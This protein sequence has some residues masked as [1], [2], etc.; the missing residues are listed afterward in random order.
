MHARGGELHGDPRPWDRL[1]ARCRLAPRRAADPPDGVDQ[2]R[3]RHRVHGVDRLPARRHDGHQRARPRGHRGG[4]RR[5]GRRAAGLP[6]PRPRVPAPREG[7][8]RASARRPHRGGRRPRAARRALP[9]GRDLRGDARGRDDGPAAGA[10]PRRAGLRPE[11]DLDRRPDRVPATARGAR[12][13]GRRGHAAHRMGGLPR[14]RLRQHRRRADP[15]CP[16]ARRPRRRRQGAH[17]CPLRVPHG[18]RV[19]VAAVRLRPPARR[20]ARTGGRGRPGRRPVHARARGSCDRPD[21]QAPRLRAAGPRP[22]HRRGEHRA[23]VRG[24]PAR[25]R[26][27]SADPVR[28]RGALD[29]AA[30]EQPRQAS[31]PRRLRAVDRGADPAADRA[32]RHNRD[33]LRTKAEKM[34]HLLDVEPEVPA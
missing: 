12:P 13:A 10:R 26:D 23:R 1:L 20:G 9:C 32:H 4:G 18:R 28:P 31:R 5:S 29:A 34:G 25:V 33:Y 3:R 17:S 21:P 24:R 30:D 22:R 6:S 19:R 15:R 16:R 11:A 14:L 7:G 27:R 2:R 8:R